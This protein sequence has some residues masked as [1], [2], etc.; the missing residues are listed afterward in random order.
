M[1]KIKNHD[2][3]ITF[4][5]LKGNPKWSL[6]TEPLWFIPYALFT[7][8]ATIYMSHIGL[9]SKE[10]G[11]TISLG[12]SLQVL[13]ALLGGIITDKMGRRNATFIFDFISWSIPCLIWAFAQNFWWFLFAAII[14]AS[15]QITNAS[16]NCLFV[17]D[18]PPKHLTN[19][20]TLIQICGLLSIFF[21]PIA[22][23]L[24]DAFSVVAVVRVLYFISA[25]SMGL[26]FY[27]LYHFG[28]E[29]EVGVRRMEETKDISYFDMFKGYK[30]VF[31]SILKSSKMLFVIF[32][33]ALSNI[34]LITTNNFF[35]LYITEALELSDGLVAVFPMVRTLMM[36][37]CIAFLQN[38][39]NRLQMKKSLITGFI[40]YVLSH[41]VLLLAPTKSIIFICI[42]TILEATAYAIII[43]RK[44]AL[45]AF[46]VDVK[47]RSR[48]YALF[49]ACMIALS[50]PFGYVV[51]LLFDL[52]KT[53]PFIF[54]ILLFF[55]CMI[56]ILCN[57]DIKS[58]ETQVEQA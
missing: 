9:T 8:F 6:I 55:I 39:I 33:L 25:I 54:N 40:V 48:I 26:K 29:T 24:V 3:I 52:N 7:P 47:E 28:G 38:K 57:K 20:F 4:L 49:N 34:I 16:W 32:F 2:L 45:M 14:N 18:C 51:G 44:D 22:I 21:S 46:F 23:V 58:Y 35:S 36:I 42:Y 31:L 17:E 43:P 19:A 10:I 37:I 41:I 56:M 1:K 11:L 27:L 15:Y 13:F 12:F 50:A 30:T 5:A 53:F